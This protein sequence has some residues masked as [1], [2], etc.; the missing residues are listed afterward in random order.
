LTAVDLGISRRDLTRLV[1]FARGMLDGPVR[2]ADAQW[3]ASLRRLHEHLIAPVQDARL[4]DGVERIIV[5]PHREL[6]YLP[7]AALLDSRGR[8][9][10]EAY[11]VGYAP[12]A[13]A[14][15]T[16]G[17]RPRRSPSRG[18]L[19]LAPR[20]ESLPATGREV[21]AMARLEGDE[22][23]VLRDGQAS[24]ERFLRDAGLY[25]VLHLATYG[26][27]NKHNPLFSFVDLAPGAGADGRL[28]VHEVLGLDLAADLVV[29]SA[30]QTALGSGASADI[31]E[32]DDWVGLTRAFLYAGAQR[33]VATLWAVEDR[34]IADLMER[35]HANRYAGLD[36]M[37]ALA[38]A[39]R[40]L[41]A[42]PVSAHPVH[43][44]AAV[45]V[46]QQEGVDAR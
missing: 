8:F 44:A 28:E 46:G 38:E 2:S 15:L 9:L 10:I 39:Q 22:V 13:S 33:V 35:F 37:T 30:C 4:L 17:D 34:S 14:W 24:E 23:S 19:A 45:L 36:D 26:S 7:F 5:V 29:L 6:H 18:V 11:A 40:R 3:R 31:P 21:M 27:L 12:S 41:L 1:E 43:W 42:D 32:G 25:Q 16:L 20:T